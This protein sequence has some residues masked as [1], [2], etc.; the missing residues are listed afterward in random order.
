[1]VKLGK[2]A[3]HTSAHTLS[4]GHTKVKA[5]YE[6]EPTLKFLAIVWALNK[7]SGVRRESPYPFKGSK[8][9]TPLNIIMLIQALIAAQE[10]LS[11]AAFRSQQALR[12]N[13][14]RKKINKKIR[15]NEMPTATLQ[16]YYH[17]AKLP[18]SLRHG[19]GVLC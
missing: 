3:G 12:C 13:L 4:H 19:K 2:N 14:P 6:L 10:L 11:Q 9:F 15:W 8:N 5:V 1:M 16:Q 7:H 17:S 18:L